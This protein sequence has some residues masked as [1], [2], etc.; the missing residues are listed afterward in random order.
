MLAVTAAV[1]EINQKKKDRKV[2]HV[3]FLFLFFILK[4][5]IETFEICL[6]D[7][8]YK[9]ENACCDAG[10]RSSSSGRKQTIIISKKKIP[11]S[12]GKQM[13]HV[14]IEKGKSKVSL[15]GNRFCMSYKGIKSFFF[16]FLP[17]ISFLPFISFL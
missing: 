13:P 4:K 8:C 10:L 3:P 16:S 11:D 9:Q 12:L 7:T 5:I 14:K 2:N 17:L 15:G 6:D 1:L